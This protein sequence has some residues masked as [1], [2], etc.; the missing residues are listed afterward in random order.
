MIAFVL[1]RVFLILLLVAANAFF[2]A[3]EFALVSVRDTRIQQLIEAR[4]IGARIVQKLHRNLDEVVNGVQLGIT[5]TSLTLGWVGE[6]L[7]ARMVEGSIGRI[8]H[9]ALYSHGIAIV[10]AFALI[11]TLH[12]ILGELIPKSLALQRAE[13]VAL[14]VAGPMDVFLTIS[15]PFLF[16]MSRA[17]GVVLRIF[18]SRKIRQGPIHSPDELKL[19]VTASRQFGEIPPFQEEMIHKAL[20]LDNVTVREVMV[21]RPDIFSLPG[22]LTLSDALGRV[23]EEQHSRIPVYDPQRGPEHIIGVLYAKDLMRW[24]RLR[25]T[26]H[27][28]QPV[29]GR[30]ADMKISQI[31]HD[32]LV[33]PETKV[34]TE[35]LEEFKDR[36]RHLAVVVDE[37]GSTAGVITVEDILEQLVGEIEDEF[38]VPPP[39]QPVLEGKIVLVLEGSFSIRDLESQY[40]LSLPRDAGFETLAGFVLARL[41]KIPKLGESFDYEGHRFTVAEME[42]HRIARVKIEKLEPARLGQVGD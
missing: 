23:V 39:E 21:P 29:A 13:Q 32:V 25:L 14:A 31:M 5:V 28:I 36:K 42:G 34:L 2:A 3:A 12:V 4:R 24:T 16:T 10:V 27:P 11:T 1:L 9:A 40:Q 8:P 33:V 17:A 41:Q 20:E 37:F 7:L 15:R 38:D 19:I 22:D 18:G 35:L 26:M 30:I 6:P